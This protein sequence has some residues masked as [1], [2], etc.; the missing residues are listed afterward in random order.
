MFRAKSN[1]RPA[2][3]ATDAPMP[4]PEAPAA[5]A[6]DRLAKLAIS[7]APTTTPDSLPATECFNRRTARANR[8]AAASRVDAQPHADLADAAAFEKVQRQDFAVAQRQALDGLVELLEV[9][10][11]EGRGAGVGLAAVAPFLLG[12]RSR[13][14]ARGAAGG[15]RSAWR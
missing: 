15:S 9:V 3:A 13:P 1:A 2:P 5:L 14:R 10:G 7:S 6:S 11:V 8:L 12:V 4:I